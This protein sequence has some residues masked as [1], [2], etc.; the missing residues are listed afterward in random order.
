MVTICLVVDLMETSPWKVEFRVELRDSL[1]VKQAPV[2][3]E[4]LVRFQVSELCSSKT[5]DLG[6]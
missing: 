6:A 1:K 2:K 4:S 3:G 5:G